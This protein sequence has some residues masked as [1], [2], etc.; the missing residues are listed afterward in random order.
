MNWGVPERIAM[1]IGGHETRAV[2]ILYHIV[3]TDDVTK[4]DAAA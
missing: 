3:N 2:S 4:R 1:K